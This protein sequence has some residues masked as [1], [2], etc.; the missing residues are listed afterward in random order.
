MKD[1]SDLTNATII[2]IVFIF[3][4]IYLSYIKS[5]LEVR[6]LQKTNNCNPLNLIIDSIFSSDSYYNDS[7]KACFKGTP[8]YNALLTRQSK[9]SMR[10]D[11]AYDEIDKINRRI[12]KTNKKANRKIHRANKN[13][14]KTQSRIDDLMDEQVDINTNINDGANVLTSLY[15]TYTDTLRSFRDS[16][17]SLKKLINNSR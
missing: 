7:Y 10:N 1:F 15:D 14:E 5:K 17:D 9:L 11:E 12:H 16:L 8:E 3:L 2:I 6:N 13:I 4:Y